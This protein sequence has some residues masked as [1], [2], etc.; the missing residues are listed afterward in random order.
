LV[1]PVWILFLKS[2]VHPTVAGIL[3]AFSVPI[4]QKVKTTSFIQ[5]LETIVAGIKKAPVLKTPILSKGQMNHMSHLKDWSSKYQSPLQTL[6]HGLHNWVGYFIIPVFALSN[7]GVAIN[8]SADLDVPLIMHIIVAL[9]LGKG[10]G[11]PLV[12]FLAKQLKLIQIPAD[13]NFKQ[14]IGVSFIAGI[15]FTMAIFIA[16]LAFANSP[17]FISSAKIGILIASFIAAIAGYVMLR[18]WC[19][20]KE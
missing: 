13:I 5:Q 7:A 15:G 3:L 18:L 16:G 9:V 11:I 4:S 17:Q 2:G 10:L 12:I 19:P 8:G 6:E 20:K 14:I 1:V